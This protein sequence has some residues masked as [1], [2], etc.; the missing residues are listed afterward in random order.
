[1]SGCWDCCHPIRSSV[2]PLWSHNH[3][4]SL[5]DQCTA[6]FT[7]PKLPEGLQNG[8]MWGQGR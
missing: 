3:S 4:I 1:M 5:L 6:G 2:G 7:S 8:P